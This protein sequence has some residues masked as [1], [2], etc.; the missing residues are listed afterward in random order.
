MNFFTAYLALALDHGLLNHDG[1]RA[2]YPRI[3]AWDL[4]RDVT[5]HL[6][7]TYQDDNQR[8]HYLDVSRL[9]MR[10]KGENVIIMAAAS[11]TVPVNLTVVS[12][13]AAH[14]G[15]VVDLMPNSPS[16]TAMD[17]C[18]YSYHDLS[19]AY[20]W[21]LEARCKLRADIDN[22]YLAR[23]SRRFMYNTQIEIVRL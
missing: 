3:L 7:I 16:R 13:C 17:L 10:V 11:F 15:Y 9:Q 5:A 19:H 4:P 14:R 12:L 2:D 20:S 1:F 18:R 22:C 6:A 8:A 23:L 21:V